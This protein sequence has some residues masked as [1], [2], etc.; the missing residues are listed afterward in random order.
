MTGVQFMAVKGMHGRHISECG[1]FLGRTST[2]AMR[3]E[4]GGERTYQAP[5][6]RGLEMLPLIY[7]FPNSCCSQN[8]HEGTNKPKKGYSNWEVVCPTITEVHNQQTLTVRHRGQDRWAALGLGS[9]TL[10]EVWAK[11]VPTLSSLQVFRQEELR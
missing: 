10:G 11:P 3:A 8:I 9:P 1:S 5:S 4:P 2:V 7:K 6:Q